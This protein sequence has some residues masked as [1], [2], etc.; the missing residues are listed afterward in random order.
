M[1]LMKSGFSRTA[2]NYQTVGASL[3][4]S[5]IQFISKVDENYIEVLAQ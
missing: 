5:T 3:I 2:D 1:M 4:N